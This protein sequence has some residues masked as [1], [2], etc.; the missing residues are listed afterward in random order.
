MKTTSSARSAALLL[1]AGLCSFACRKN[2]PPPE[3]KP[4][5]A[6]VA[7]PVAA[8]PRVPPPVPDPTHWLFWVAPHELSAG[9]IKLCLDQ[10]CSSAESVLAVYTL[11]WQRNGDYSVQMAPG[12]SRAD[13]SYRL[14]ALHPSTGLVDNKRYFQI[15]APTDNPIDSNRVWVRLEPTDPALKPFSRRLGM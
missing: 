9:Q 11:T 6:P 12:G 7:A 10:S 8:A 1:T 13:L 3:V 15:E 14:P 5:P 4:A 2:E